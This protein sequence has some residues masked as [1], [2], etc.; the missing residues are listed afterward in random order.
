[1]VNYSLFDRLRVVVE[2]DQ[3][4]VAKSI[5]DEL[6][7]TSALSDEAYAV[8]ATGETQIPVLSSL[9]ALPVDWSKIRIF[10]LDEFAGIGIDHPASFARFIKEKIADKIGISSDRLHLIDGTLDPQKE[11]DRYAGE[12]SV[13]SPDIC[14][15]G[16]GDN[17]HIAFNEPGSIEPGEYSD[18]VRE[19]SAR[20]D[21]SGSNRMETGEYD[22]LVR[23]DGESQEGNSLPVREYRTKWPLVKVVHLDESTRLRQVEEGLFGNIDEA[24]NMAIT[25]SMTAILNARCIIAVCTGKHKAD[26]VLNMLKGD[27]SPDCPASLLRLHDNATLFL[28]RA[29]AARLGS[30]LQ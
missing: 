19:M 16:I 20:G 17:C 24:P 4:L 27:I 30:D 6:A 15:L 22:D 25:L 8:F 13:H 14:M 11:C 1:M 10:H 23:E 3:Q 9:T 28:D 18:L 7:H 29:A 21:G 12:L 5:A 2:N 26:A